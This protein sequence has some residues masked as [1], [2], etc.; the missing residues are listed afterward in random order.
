[1]CKLNKSYC[2]LSQENTSSYPIKF[3]S[4][5]LKLTRNENQALAETFVV[6]YFMKII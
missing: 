2:K 4:S 5:Y 6:R 3:I 1:M